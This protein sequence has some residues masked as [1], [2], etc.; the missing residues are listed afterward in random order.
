MSM[1]EDD[2]G[3]GTPPGHGDLCET[4]K[5]L[6]RRSSHVECNIRTNSLVC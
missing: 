6:L 1:V 5:V 3:T 4:P 2:R